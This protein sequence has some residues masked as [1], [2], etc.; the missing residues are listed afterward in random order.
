MYL[1]DP[2][3]HMM[4][5]KRRTYEALLY[6]LVNNKL[7]KKYIYTLNSQ[8]VSCDCTTLTQVWDAG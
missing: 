5:Y 4:A 1:F 8:Y 6:I 2:E 3:T 7:N